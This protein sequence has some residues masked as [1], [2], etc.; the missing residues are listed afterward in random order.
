MAGIY[1]PNRAAGGQNGTGLRL[2]ELGTKGPKLPTDTLLATTQ[3]LGV[4]G[5]RDPPGPPPGASRLLLKRR[6]PSPESRGSDSGEENGDKAPLTTRAHQGAHAAHEDEDAVPEWYPYLLAMRE[7]RFRQEFVYLTLRDPDAVLYR[8]YDLSVVQHSQIDPQSFYTLSAHGVTHMLDG[9]AEFQTLDQFERQFHLYRRVSRLRIFRLYKLWKAFAM[10]LSYIRR[11][12]TRLA[13]HRLESSLFTLSPLHQKALFDIRD[14]CAKL[15]ELPLHAF[16]FEEARRLEDFRA[17]QKKHAK[18]CVEQLKDFSQFVADTV[19][20]TCQADMDALEDRLLG[21]NREVA[22]IAQTAEQ[23]QNTVSSYAVTAAKRSEQRRLAAFIRLVDFMVQETLR[24][25]LHDSVA[26]VADMLEARHDPESAYDVTWA[27]SKIANV[28]LV[29]THE[30]PRPSNASSFRPGSGPDAPP[31][32]AVNPAALPALKEEEERRAEAS[33]EAKRVGMPPRASATPPTL[34]PEAP[35]G[36]REP[37]REKHVPLFHVSIV[38]EDGLEDPD[39]GKP[40]GTILRLEPAPADV[41]EEVDA[42]LDGY[43]QAV[44]VV[45]RLTANEELQALV[46]EA[47]E[48]TQTHGHETFMDAVNDEVHQTKVSTVRSLVHQEFEL[49]EHYR[50]T[51]EPMKAILTR[52]AATSRETLQ[53]EAER[54]ERGLERFEDDMQEYSERMEQIE[55]LPL[56]QNLG[57][58][59]V[60]IRPMVARMLPGPQRCIDE[61]KAVLPVLAAARY[62]EFIE[63]VHAVTNSLGRGPQDVEGLVSFLE[64]LEATLKRRETFDDRFHEV[65]SH[66][67]LIAKFKIAVPPMEMAAFQTMASDFDRFRETVD[68][69]EGA[70]DGYI[71]QFQGDVQ[72]AEQEMVAEAAEVRMTA[73]DELIL[74]PATDP[75]RALRV[76]QNLTTRIEEMLAQRDKIARYRELFK[77]PSVELV[78]VTECAQEVQLKHLLWQSIQ[79]WRALTSSWESTRFAELEPDALEEKVQSYNRTAAKVERNLPPNRVV[80]TFKDAVVDYKDL[81][82][83]VANLR[84]EHLKDRHF[85]KVEEALGHMLD[86]EEMTLGDLLKLGVR[87]HHQRIVAISTEATQEHAL[88]MMLK[89]V[90]DK[91][92]EIEFVVTPYKDSKDMFV[93]GGVE[94]VMAALEDSMMTMMTINASRYVTG[95]RAEVERFET[96][97]KLFSETLD[98][99]L[100]CQKTWMYLETIFS[101]PDIQRQL[102]QESKMFFNVDRQ[103]KEA[104]RRTHERPSALQAGTV[105]GLLETLQKCNETL[106]EVQKRLEDYL[107]TKRIAFP[108]FYFLSNDELLEI[109]SETKNP[110][111]VQPHLQKCFDG[112]KSLQFGTGQGA[113]DILAMVS[114]EGEVVELPP[115]LKA[116]GNIESW[117]TAV[118]QGMVT[119]LKRLGKQAWQTYPETPRREWILQQ[120]AQLVLSV[121][122]IYWCGEVER[123]FESVDPLGSLALFLERNVMQ[124]TELSEMV[125]GDLSK[126]HRKILVT[127]ITIDVHNRDIVDSLKQEQC[128]RA[129]D[130]TWQMQLRYYYDS[131]A[132]NLTIRQVTAGFTYGYEYLGAQPRLVVTPMTDRCYMTLTGALHLKLGGAPAGPAGTGKTET[133][134]DLGKALGVQCVVFN[135]GDNLDYKFME[136]FFSGLA[137]CGAWACFD[138]FNRIDIEVLSVV[139]QQLLTIQNALKADVERFLF[140]GREMRLIPTCGVFI[141]MNPGYAG[142]TELPDNLKALFR[143]MAMMIPDYGLVAEVMLFAEGFADARSLSRKMVK[144]YKLSSEQLSKQDHYD[145]GMRALKSVLV[146][147]GALKR[148]SPDLNEDIVL[149]RAMRD[150]NIPKFLSADARLFGAIIQDLFP[151][152]DIPEQDFGALQ[153]ALEDVTVKAGLQAVPAFITKCIQLHITFNVRFG[154]MLVGPTGGG[155]SEIYAMLKAAMTKLRQ[156]R[157]PDPEFQKVHTF[158]FNPKAIS[159]GELYGEVSVLTGEWT[160]GLGSTLIRNARNDDSEDRKWVVFDGPVDAIWIENMN[161]VLDDNCTLCLPNGERIKLNPTTMRMLFEVQDLAVAS[162]ATVSRCGMVY[163]PAEDVG[164]QPYA[165]TWLEGLNARLSNEE[166]RA[167]MPADTLQLIWEQLEKHVPAGLAYLADSG[168]PEFVPSVDVNLVVS[169][170]K[171]IEALLQPEKGLDVNKPLGDIRLALKNI[172]GFSFVWALGGNLKTEAWDAFDTFVRGQLEGDV[173]WPNRGTVFDYFVVAENDWQ[174][175][176]WSESVSPFTYDPA[177]PYFALIVPTLDTTRYSYLLTTTLS[178]QRPTLFTGL[179]GVG[180]TAVIDSTLRNLSDSSNVAPVFINFSAQTASAPTQELFESKLEKMGKR[181]IPAAGKKVAMFV[182]DINMPAREKY[183][184]QPPIELLR[185]FLDRGGLYDRKKLFWKEVDDVTLVAACAPPGG[186][187][188]DVTPRFFRHFTM[189]NMPQPSEAVMESIFRAICGGFLGHFFKPEFN[190]LLDPMVR[191]SVEAFLRISQ[192]LLPTPTKSHYTFNLRDVSKVFQGVL[193]IRPAQCP[194]PDVMSRLWAHENMRVF[195][196]RLTDNQ[197]K[198]WFKELLYDSM[199][200]KFAIDATFEDLFDDKRPILFGDFLR[201]GVAPADKVYEEV[202]DITK[203]AKLLDDYLDEYNMV[204][205][206]RMRLVFF[207]DAI[208]HVTRIAR[209]LRQPRGNAMLVGVGGSGKQ[210]L[211]R[212]AT[213]MA[214]YQC[215]QIELTRG[216]GTN[217]FRDDIKSLFQV[218]GVEGRPIVFLFTDTQILDEGFVEDINSILNTGEVPGL[219]APDEKDKVLNDLREICDQLGLPVSRDAIWAFFIKRVRDNLHLV[220]CMSPVGDAFRSRCRQFPSLISCTTIDWFSKW[221]EEALISVSTQFLENLDLGGQEINKALASIC[222]EIHTSV[223]ESCQKFF[224]ELRRHY[225]TTP[226]SYLDLISSYTELLSEKRGSLGEARDRLVNGLE[227]L[228]Q[229]NEVVDKMQAELNELQPVL[230]EKTAAAQELLLQVSREQADAE[231]IKAVVSKEEREVTKEALETQKLKDDAQQELDDVLPELEAATKALNSLNKSDITEIKSFA[232]PPPL[233]QLTMEGV[234]ILLSEKTDWDSAKKVLGDGNFMAR[235]VNFDKENIAEPLLKKLKRITTEGAFTPESVGA[236][237]KA[238]KSLCMWVKSMEKYAM[239]VKVVEPKRRDLAAAEEKLNAMML[240]L[241]EK[242]AQLQEVVDKVNGLQKQLEDTQS[243][244]KSLQEQADIS[245]RR[246]TRAGKLTSALGDE[247]VRWTETAGTIAEQMV[248]LVGD[249]FLGSACVAYVGAFTGPYRE[250]LIARWWQRCK[251]MNVPVAEHFSLSSVLSSPVEIRDW[252]IQGLPTDSVSVDNGIFVTRGRRWPLMIDP[253]GQANRWVRSMEMKNGLRP[254]KLNDH[255]LLRVLETSIRNGN[256]VL[257]EDIAEHLDPALEPLLQKQVFQQGN[258][259]LI[260][261]GDS[262]VDYNPAFRFYITTKMP[263]PHY[264]PEICIKVTLINF[265]VTQKGLEDQLLGDVV[266]KERPDLEEQKDRLVVSISNDKRQLK[267]LEDKILK[268]LKES[269]GNILDDEVLINTLNNSKL[270]SGVIQGRVQEA[271]ETEKMINASREEYRVVAQRGSILYFVVADLAQIDP[272]YQYS[273]AYF[274]QLFNQCID[275]SEK[276]DDLQTRLNSLMTY[277]TQFMY[278]TVCR[279][280]FEAHKGIYSF[281]I[282]TSILRH[283]GHIRHDE[284]NFLLR[285][286]ILADSIPAK[287]EALSWVKQTEWEAAV[288]LEHACERFHGLTKGVAA[289]AEA[290][291]AWKELESPQEHDFPTSWL[292]AGVKADHFMTLP[293][294]RVFREDRL[295]FGMQHY[296]GLELGKSFTESPP[297]SL[298]SVFPDTSKTTP[299]VFILSTGADPTSMLQRFSATKDRVAGERLHIISLGQGQG[300]HAEAAIEAARKNGDW[301]CLQNCHLA[302]SWMTSL[303]KRVEEL[304]DRNAS[305]HPDFRLWL[306]SMPAAHFPVPVLQTSIKITIEPPKGLRANLL[307]SLNDQ[308]DGFLDSCTKEAPWHKLVFAC[309]FFHA[310]VQ[311]R[312]KFGPL[313]WN[314]RYEFSQGDLDCS[315]ATLRMFLDEQDEIPWSA[316]LYVTG[317]INYGGRVTDDNDRRLLMCILERYYNP[318]VLRDGY[319]FNPDGA[320]HVPPLGTK[321]D[322]VAYVKSLPVSEAPDVYGMHENANIAFYVQDSKKVIATVL[323]MQPRVA[324]AQG[325]KTPEETILELAGQLEAALPPV[326]DVAVVPEKGNPFAPLESGHDNSLGVFLR[327]EVE[328]FNRLLETIRSTLADLQKA[329]KGL[330]VMSAELEGMFTAMLNNQVPELWAAVAYPSL[331]P[332]AAWMR[333]FLQRMDFIAKWVHEGEPAVF[334]LPAFFFPQG[335]MTAALQNHARKTQVAIDR[336]NFGFRVLE[337]REWERIESQPD[338]GIY[339]RGLFLD[340]AR[341]DDQ[342][343]CLA[344][345]LPGAMH[346]ELPPIHFEPVID[347]DPSPELYSCP[348]YKTSVRAGVLNT[349]G[350]STNYVLSIDLKAGDGNKPSHWTLQGVAALCAVP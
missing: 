161:T 47:N 127:L 295:T 304:Q 74:D 216:Y 323:T 50:A 315:L 254:L 248:Q 69:S 125:R 255:N 305:V 202:K 85:Q 199:R 175:K 113:A 183:G 213:F 287:P 114:S 18:Y 235:L 126:L 261:L 7:N 91:W 23:E 274:S 1:L 158:T 174:M 155:K 317:Q 41:S 12:K 350:Q 65:N 275:S 283:A 61:I 196:D 327:Q 72:N 265:T 284:W 108:R 149:I 201:M 63:D 224:E 99:W 88:E 182:D 330:V 270:T 247:A 243:E 206:S 260:R 321:E 5:K 35:A 312:R 301:I 281:L 230:K 106:E 167:E 236:V 176:N 52:Y 173:A 11:K 28:N 292:A 49:A 316:L 343:R 300:V 76:T 53:A 328:Q 268:L 26:E 193:L 22:M 139:A 93:L 16:R 51:F 9:E 90:Q 10:W 87:E 205:T 219:Y 249:V 336:L 191:C 171:W 242:Q 313:G 223:Q 159:M 246:L 251:D 329:I 30:K 140:A 279:G 119:T 115:N 81:V 210:S 221:P 253:Q 137:Q 146:L 345:A 225:Y 341:W 170:T 258:R 195:H 62:R 44:G 80:S 299:I 86:R 77:L 128:T 14:R 154:V 220:L 105:P 241:G 179:S 8:P 20:Q 143:P 38:L 97:L 84:N 101:A 180:K 123:A 212:F 322:Y 227:K 348:L 153:R 31:L 188:Q 156:D 96:S 59:L 57:M 157:N 116:R 267:D 130:F 278:A 272:M 200:S 24:N 244:L 231:K 111:A 233:V 204:S 82:P 25:M 58:L 311:E 98:E 203:L 33:R 118:E 332:L 222:V 226:K 103:Y 169:L 141:T 208:Q 194:T 211:T 162:P 286:G 239:V 133:T 273:L 297:F 346:S 325:E 109:L 189:L 271:E 60:D 3:K 54:G 309:S 36:E 129:T 214:E 164:W 160:E 45:R 186:G 276:S 237:S 34:A 217:E 27:V 29:S 285:G 192:E 147:A 39:D 302:K 296:V 339:I 207:L 185:L 71:M 100:E 144:L 331:K 15:Q 240:K 324:A 291:R 152:V 55:L 318:E 37:P 40:Q 269:Q 70:K 250:E 148:A 342:E 349:T 42:T 290:W 263:N 132:D 104:M 117:L 6:A 306:T 344:E 138:E 134:K 66:Y 229:T 303:E 73:Q 184:A 17:A 197:D 266:R 2:G 259:T 168:R 338:N 209:I 187:R 136:K 238:A 181:L 190:R 122:N 178:I 120:P 135:C 110:Q 308:P 142:R 46:S 228:T 264:L 262:D 21:R 293:L 107:E 257:L 13:I 335:F 89:K 121:S 277:T 92:A 326:I 172:F 215:F 151:G 4:T 177:L 282:C 234:C 294:L 245:Q 56:D 198:L 298:S 32:S 112:I 333:D 163:V 102:V 145:F 314:I 347:Y 288:M 307:R 310:V 337:E 334:W 166:Y 48:P 319:P 83:V 232:K 165:K 19:I 94:D 79:E 340:C 131:D 64:V 75:E 78:D 289:E 95:I 150:S 124:L 320:Y 43:L 67:R 280:L 68:A 218:A 252:N 256:P